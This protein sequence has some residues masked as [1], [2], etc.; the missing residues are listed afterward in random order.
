M[1]HDESL[2]EKNF[3]WLVLGAMAAAGG[4]T[5]YYSDSVWY[6]GGAVAA[7]PATLFAIWLLNDVHTHWQNGSGVKPNGRVQWRGEN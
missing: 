3:G 5:Y 6:A 4:L 7:V 2:V 1:S